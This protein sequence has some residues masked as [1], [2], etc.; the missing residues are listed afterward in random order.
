[1]SPIIVASIV[2][3]VFFTAGSLMCSTTCH[4]WAE[5]MIVQT[6]T[7]PQQQQEPTGTPFSNLFSEEQVQERIREALLAHENRTLVAQQ[8]MMERQVQDRVQEA[9]RAYNEQTAKDQVRRPPCQENRGGEKS[10][11]AFQLPTGT[12][13]LVSGMATAPRIEFF[14]KFNSLGLGMPFNPDWQNNN[15]VIFMY[16]DASALPQNHSVSSDAAANETGNPPLLSVEEATE[17]CDVVNV[18]LLSTE[19]NARRCLAFVAGGGP[20]GYHLQR[21]ARLPPPQTRNNGRVGA[22]LDP[23]APLRLVGR[24]QN[25]EGRQ[26]APLPSNDQS[27]LYRSILSRYLDS[28]ETVLERLSPIAAAAAVNNTIVVMTCNFGQ[29]EILVNFVCG[30]RRRNLDLSMVVVF[31]ADEETRDIAVGLGL[32]TYYDDVNFGFIP[33]EVSP[34]GS[35]LFGTVVRLCQSCSCLT[36]LG[37]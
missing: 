8:E 34:F 1:M 29:S 19:K 11:T 4:D 22:G 25:L 26:M 3:I 7:T 15:Q 14:N 32:H 36:S 6:T 35:L 2:G 9:M 20:D 13:E 24:F 18:A 30:A 37:L 27:K 33:K 23:T 28:L 5:R 12:G 31:A 10:T 21:F 17:N 16:R